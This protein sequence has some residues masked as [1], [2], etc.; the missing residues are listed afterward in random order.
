[1]TEEREQE[2]PPPFD[3][4]PPV[5]PSEPRVGDSKAVFFQPEDDDEHPD[6]GE[7]LTGEDQEPGSGAGGEDEE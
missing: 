3:E 6:E 7:E 4:D 1:M 2:S 5:D